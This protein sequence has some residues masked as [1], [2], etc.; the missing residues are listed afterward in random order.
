MNRIT[1]LLAAILALYGAP[2]L[3]GCWGLNPDRPLTEVPKSITT[4]AT[5]EDPSILGLEDLKS[6]DRVQ[7]Q[8]LGNNAWQVR[9]M[10]MTKPWTKL[11]YEPGCETAPAPAKRTEPARPPV[12][13]DAP[14]TE[15]PAAQDT[16]TEEGAGGKN[17]YD[18][19][20][21]N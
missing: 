21:K 14:A 6:G 16:P 3:A 13:D 17:K 7:L 10:N 4:M 19:I 1:L 20:K 5:V 12:V 15:P 8:N 2:A 11:Q 9:P 18:L